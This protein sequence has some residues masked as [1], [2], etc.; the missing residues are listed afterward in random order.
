MR[1]FFDIKASFYLFIYILVLGN[2]NE[3]SAEIPE[4]VELLSNIEFK[5][6]NDEKL[7]L[8][9]YLNKNIS[10]NILP[11]VIFF[12]GGGFRKGSKNDVSKLEF[13]AQTLLSL[14]D[15][16]KIV[17]AA[18]QIRNTD[19]TT[20]LSDIISDA[21]DAVNWLVDNS[22]IYKIDTDRIG[23]IGFSSGGTLA[24]S[25]GLNSS[26]KFIIAISAA[27]DFLRHVKESELDNVKIGP[28]KKKLL[29]NLFLGT[30]DQFPENYSTASPVNFIEKNSPP[31]LLIA[32]KND[33]DF[34]KH[35]IWLKEKGDKIGANINFITVENARHQVYRNYKNM[36]PSVEQ[37]SEEI[38]KVII[39]YF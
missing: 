20:S 38:K 29:N 16:G 1:S 34:F 21:N 37:L 19:Q 17:L 35:S 9:I 33:K 18:P 31:I 2:T 25:T 10:D 14:V 4:S 32:G 39:N 5:S 24:L 28:S 12:H 11:L 27:T 36:S 26:A 7:F 13:F 15:Q 23:L 3:L 6:I 22:R 8:D 30:I